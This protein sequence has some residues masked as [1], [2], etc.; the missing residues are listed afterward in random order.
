MDRIEAVELALHD[1]GIVPCAAGQLIIARP[2]VTAE[3]KS[4]PEGI[5]ARSTDQHIVYKV[6]VQDIVTRIAH[7][8]NW[9]RG[10]YSRTPQ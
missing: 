6:P 5:V 8:T 4:A 7:A 9:I 1:V 3:A 2:I 10:R